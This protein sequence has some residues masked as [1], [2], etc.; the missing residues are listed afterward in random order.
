[1]KLA[2]DFNE[3]R[4]YTESAAWSRRAVELANDVGGPVAQDRESSYQIG[5][6]M[7]ARDALI[8]ALAN[9]R[10]LDQARSELAAQISDLGT[11]TPGLA[12]SPRAEEGAG[13]G[14]QRN[15]ETMTARAWTHLS[16]LRRSGLSMG[17]LE[18]QLRSAG[19]APSGPEHGGERES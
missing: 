9:R 10:D 8:T 5:L 6:R 15:L 18:R 1:M 3:L 14:L 17:D 11:V 13:D 12:P 2:A 4:N 19:G 7:M 16:W